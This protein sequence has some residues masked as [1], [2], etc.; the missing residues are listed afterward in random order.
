[1]RVGSLFPFQT[2][3]YLNGHSFIEQG[4]KRAGM[5]HPEGGCESV[6][7]ILAR[8]PRCVKSVRWDGPTAS[9]AKLGL[10]SKTGATHDP[11]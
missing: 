4:L 11:N 10:S 7:A 6:V 5:R 3:Y 1:M 8:R 9:R 2:T